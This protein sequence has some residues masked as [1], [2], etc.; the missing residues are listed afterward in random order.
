MT[1]MRK[2][3]V[4]HGRVQGVGFRYKAK[5]LA[6]SL[7]LSGWVRNEY[8][9]TVHMEVQGT[10]QMIHK[11]MEGL[12]RDR[13]ISIEWIDEKDIPVDNEERRFSVR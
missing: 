9:G 12:N 13:Y 3:L 1:Q 5:Y 7:G 11:L 2:R 8:D 4:F 10:K 6:S